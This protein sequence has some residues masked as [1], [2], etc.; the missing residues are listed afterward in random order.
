MFL[1]VIW[2]WECRCVNF[3]LV[4]LMNLLLLW[5]WGW[6]VLGKRDWGVI[7]GCFMLLWLIILGVIVGLVIVCF[8]VLVVWLLGL[9]F[10]MCGCL[11]WFIVVVFEVFG[12]WSVVIFVLRFKLLD[13]F[14]RWRIF[15][16]E[17]IRIRWVSMLIYIRIIVRMFV[18]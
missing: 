18:I 2:F 9:C 6:V 7:L 5:C 3:F 1:F 17:F 15:I 4:C 12:F 10:I 16:L 14:K 11:V 8:I 13:V